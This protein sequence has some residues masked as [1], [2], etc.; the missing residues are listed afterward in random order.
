ML[1]FVLQCIVLKCIAMVCNLQL[2]SEL[3][4]LLFLDWTCSS[5]VQ[6]YCQS[7]SDPIISVKLSFRDE[8]HFRKLFQCL[9]GQ[10]YRILLFVNQEQFCCWLLRFLAAITNWCSGNFEEERRPGHLSFF[11]IYK[12]YFNLVT[13]IE[14]NRMINCVQGE[15]NEVFMNQ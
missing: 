13:L 1:C 6:K 4:N 5:Q 11:A 8:N 9:F 14:K 15:D 10:I 2:P 7:Y 12:N 3:V